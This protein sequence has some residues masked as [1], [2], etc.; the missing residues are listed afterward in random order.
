MTRAHNLPRPAEFKATL[1]NLGFCSGKTPRRG[2]NLTVA[3]NTKSERNL[4][5]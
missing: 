3:E 1:R 4:T 5:F 2:I